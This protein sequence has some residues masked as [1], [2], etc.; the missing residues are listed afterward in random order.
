MKRFNTEDA[1]TTDK[2][3]VLKSERQKILQELLAGIGEDGFGMELHAFDFVAAVAEAH[4]DAVVGFGGDG[5]LARQRFFF[6][7]QGMVT[8]GREGIGKLAK[9]ILAVMMNLAGFSVKKFRRAND[10]PAE[11]GADGLMAQTHT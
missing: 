5:K 7:D 8:R 10:F 9:N 6:D 4:D 1:E 11:C 2:N 3:L